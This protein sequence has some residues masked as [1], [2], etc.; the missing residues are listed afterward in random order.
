MGCRASSR[1]RRPGLERWRT[2]NVAVF[3]GIDWAE[4]QHDVAIVDD[5]GQL[6]L[7]GNYE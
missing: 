1:P 2:S 4:T 5:D 6:V 7:N 3:C